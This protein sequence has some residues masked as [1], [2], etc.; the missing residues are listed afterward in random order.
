[1]K[2]KYIFLVLLSLVLLLDSLNAEV[3][4][5]YE[6]KDIN[7]VNKINEELEGDEWKS[8]YQKR[9]DAR[10]A[11]QQDEMRRLTGY[12]TTGKIP[13]N[14]NRCTGI[15]CPS[16]FT[17]NHDG[18]CMKKCGRVWCIVSTDCEKDLFGIQFCRPPRGPTKKE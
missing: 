12:A 4:Q 9:E 8:P 18:V 14:V 17:C 6:I 10:L 11:Q 1:M 15:K 3:F 5:D 16:G 13:T 2:I 7:E